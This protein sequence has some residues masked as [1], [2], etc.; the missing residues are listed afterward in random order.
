M[1][2]MKCR[3]YIGVGMLALWC[4][5]SG[6]A[7]GGYWYLSVVNNG[8]AP[9]EV[10]VSLAKGSWK[11]GPGE[12]KTVKVDGQKDSDHGKERTLT[13]KS[14]EKSETL[15]TK[16]NH[17]NT[18]VLDV[19]SN[20]CVV[21]ADY[22]P[23]YRP[24][25]IEIPEG[26][27]DIRVVKTFKG[28]RLYVIGRVPSKKSSE[29]TFVMTQIGEKLPGKIQLS[30][31]SKELPEHVRLINVPCDLMSDPSAFYNYLNEH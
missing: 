28:E 24:K 19:A 16:I 15:T 31:G 22:G 18:V 10:S 2:S 9:A 11:V 25:E 30:P 3:W 8:T 29:G 27:T 14:G 4:A 12:A 1:R 23:Q 20:S 5:A 26:E 13:I 6:C 21:A 17:P 7:D